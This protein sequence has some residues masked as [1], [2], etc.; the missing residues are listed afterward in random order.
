MNLSELKPKQ[1]KF[2]L[3]SVNRDFDVNP[4]S[5]LDEEWLCE[6]FTPEEIYDVFNNIDMHGICRIAFRLMTDESKR[7]FKT[8]QVTF[9]TEDGEE[10]TEDIGGVELFKAMVSGGD[11]KEAIL[12][13]LNDTFGLS[14]PEVKA[15]DTNKK[16]VKKKTKKKAIK[17]K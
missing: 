5:L 9:A 11:E 6:Q 8:K 7:F 15:A 14:R 3:R 16:K 1:S 4:I 17:K 12:L 10:L 13:A 2:F